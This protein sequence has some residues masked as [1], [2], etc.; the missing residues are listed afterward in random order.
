LRALNRGLSRLG[1]GFGHLCR[2]C[3]G[4]G[5]WSSLG[6]GGSLN[7]VFFGRDGRLRRYSLAWL[8]FGLY[9]GGKTNDDDL[10]TWADFKPLSSTKKWT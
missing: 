6:L 2:F 5:F 3:H 4:F 1:R 8:E 7:L 9:F 10:L